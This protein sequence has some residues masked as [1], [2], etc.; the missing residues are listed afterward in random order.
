MR[1]C[2]LFQRLRTLAIALV[3]LWLFLSRTSNKVQ[4]NMPL[5]VVKTTMQQHKHCFPKHLQLDAS[6]DSTQRIAALG[7]TS[8]QVCWRF[9]GYTYTCKHTDSSFLPYVVHSHWMHRI[10][11]VC[12][13]GL[14]QFI[15]WARRV[16][17]SIVQIYELEKLQPI[18]INRL[19]NQ[20][21]QA[22][23]A[24]VT[25]NTGSPIPH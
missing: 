17:H 13:Q 20:S 16:T 5:K 15:R 18:T 11:L 19:L 12:I 1:S 9:Y 24:T 8:L 14:I 2:T 21:Q 22:T 3:F 4:M 6:C 25:L 7:C 23:T 10:E